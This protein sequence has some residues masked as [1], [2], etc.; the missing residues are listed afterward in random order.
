[1][2]PASIPMSLLPKPPP[3]LLPSELTL[4]SSLPTGPAAMWALLGGNDG[5]DACMVNDAIGAG[6]GDKSSCDA[7]SIL[8][9]N[10]DQG[11]GAGAAARAG[12][13][14]GAVAGAGPGA[15]GKLADTDNG[16]L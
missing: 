10:S 16:R 1:M 12:A 2:A 5:A 6:R 4:A 11:A 15:G 9:A 7:S 8:G 13:V 14:T 3:P